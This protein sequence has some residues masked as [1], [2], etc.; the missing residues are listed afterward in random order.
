VSNNARYEAFWVP[1]LNDK[2]DPDE[3]LAIAFAWLGEAERESGAAGVIVMYA[4]RMMGNRPAL[5]EAASRWPFV[6]PRSR[7]HSGLPRGTGP[8]LCVWPPDDKTLEL[9]EQ[10]AFGSA[11]CV[12]PGT[13]YDA[14]GWIARSG[15]GALVQGALTPRLPSLSKEVEAEL[16]S[17][18]FFGGH[19]M[20][21]GGGEKEQAIQTL[22]RFARLADRPTRAAIEAHLRS[23]RQVH[24]NGAERVGKWYDEVLEGRRHR[25]YRGQ[26]IG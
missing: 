17:L 11:L 19:N 10:L 15:A 1:G 26:V 13:R 21:L 24:G 12:I 2:I 8:V 14:S 3:A 18:S 4:K 25:D 20:F 23:N 5:G 7:S 22:R 6:S 9:A 16:D